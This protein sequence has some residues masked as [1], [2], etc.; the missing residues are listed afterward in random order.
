[1]PQNPTSSDAP[2]IAAH[3]HSIRHRR[4]ILDSLTCG[5]FYC[6]A[7]FTPGEVGKWVDE[8]AGVGQTALCPGCGID[9][10]IGSAA[11]YPITRDF[12]SRMHRHWFG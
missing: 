2:H 10:V 6:L 11:G 5:C 12:L 9:S 1:M 3:R 7:L 8:E 4:E